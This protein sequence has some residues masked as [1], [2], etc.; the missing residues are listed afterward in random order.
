MEEGWRVHTAPERETVIERENTET[1]TTTERI[2]TER[3]NDFN[4]IVIH[5]YTDI[6]G[7]QG[8]L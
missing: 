8:Y 6:H 2:T 7:G 4:I 5:I 3:A 1:E